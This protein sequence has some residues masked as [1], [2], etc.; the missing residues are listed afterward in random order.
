MLL[1]HFKFCSTVGDVLIIKLNISK[2]SMRWKWG[3]Q[4]VFRAKLYIYTV[5][6]RNS[7]KLSEEAFTL[8]IKYLFDLW[9]V[10]VFCKDHTVTIEH[11]FFCCMLSAKLWY[12]CWNIFICLLKEPDACFLAC[13]GIPFIKSDKNMWISMFHVAA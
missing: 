5:S 8:H 6:V 12:Y 9:N 1:M 3:L 4:Q 7:K 13:L 11:I 10:V 2:I